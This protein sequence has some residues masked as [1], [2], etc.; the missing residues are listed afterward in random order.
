L[1][2]SREKKE[3]LQFVIPVKWLPTRR[4]V[5]FVAIILQYNIFLERIILVL[6]IGARE[7]KN[8]G[9]IGK[10]EHHRYESL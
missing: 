5:N 8:C 6:G 2:E 7:L 9:Q 3:A 4:Q 10:I 1:W